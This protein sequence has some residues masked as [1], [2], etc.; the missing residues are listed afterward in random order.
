MANVIVK[1][2]FCLD[3]PF[4]RA[5]I[6]STFVV[7]TSNFEIVSSEGSKESDRD[8]HMVFHL[9]SSIHDYK[10]IQCGNRLFLIDT[11]L[12]ELTFVHLFTKVS[13]PRAFQ[14]C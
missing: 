6:N 13:S 14:L 10:R 1:V 4:P 7:H 12:I 3:F 9:F 11:Q 8:D 2:T 5:K